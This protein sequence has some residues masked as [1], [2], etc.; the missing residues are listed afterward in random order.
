MLKRLIFKFLIASAMFFFGFLSSIEAVTFRIASYNV[1]NL[2]DPDR[3]GTEYPAYLPYNHYGWTRD[4]LDKK[5]SNLARVIKGLN[6]EVVALQ[7]IESR[8][9]LILLVERLKRNAVNYPYY[10]IAAAKPTPVKC[11]VISKFPIIN[12]K[13]IK[14]D[15]DSARNILKITLNIEGAPFIV[16]VNHWKSRMGPESCRIKYAKALKKEIDKLPADSDFILTGDFN[17]CY[18]EY[19][20]IKYSKKLNDTGGVT[21]INHIL[22]TVKD[23]DMVDEKFLRKQKENEYLYNLW[24]ELGKDK[25]WSY[26]FAGKKNSFDHIIVSKGLYDNKGITYI[27]N[28][29]GRFTPGYLFYK[30]GI[31]RW[32]RAKKGKGRHLGKGYSD[33]LPV[34]ASFSTEP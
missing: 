33:H 26:I 27:D 9:A 3:D 22:M 10:K 12:K 4:M 16:F 2:F 31:Y 1:E 8:K 25:R 24:L 11:A 7:E 32:Q 6:A 17:S 13:E 29:F 18:N 14:V 21:G 34:F 28:S 23:S 5:T 15:N 20:T 19:R 30:K